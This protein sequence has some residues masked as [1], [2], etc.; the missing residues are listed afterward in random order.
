MAKVPENRVLI[1][2]KPKKFVHRLRAFIRQH[3]LS[4]RTEKAYVNWIKRLIKFHG[5]K[6]PEKM[7]S[8]DIEKFLNHQSIVLHVSINTQKSALNAFNFVF[9]RFLQR[10]LGLLSI[11]YA[12]KGRKLPSIFSHKEALCIIEQLEQPWRLI[13]QLM[14]GSGLRISEVIALRIQDINFD[15]RVISIN[16]AKGNKDR[17]SILPI[18]AIEPLRIQFDVVRQQHNHDL[19]KGHGVT[20]LIKQDQSK[21]SSTNYS[22]Q[23]IFPAKKLVFDSES[24]IEVRYHVSDKSVQRQVKGAIHRS[25][26]PKTGSPHTFRHSFATHLLENGTNIRV[27]QELLGH[28]DVSTTQI[29]THV[30]NHNS[31]KVLSPIDVLTQ[32]IDSDNSY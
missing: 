25:G 20:F 13:T 14:Y 22:C 28:T 29:Y 11:C 19:T 23:F 21:T 27:I 17:R 6:H 31:Q 8:S 32:K 7:N 12:R 10:P 16:N 30:T 5:M 4:Y 3:N 15:D 24:Q 9:N 2:S 1:P 26:V 18:E